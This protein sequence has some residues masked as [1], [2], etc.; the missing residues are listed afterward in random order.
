MR[1]CAGVRACVCAGGAHQKVRP[2][3]PALEKA[4]ASVEMAAPMALHRLALKDAAVPMTCG[5][6]VALG[7][8]AANTTPGEMATP[9]SA[10][11]H[12]RACVACVRCVCACVG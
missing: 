7:V 2:A 9:C 10:S 6:D 4:R 8:G 11:F 1:V 5:N 3:W 12:L